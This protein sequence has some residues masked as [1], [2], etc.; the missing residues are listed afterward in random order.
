MKD[1][2][3]N[4]HGLSEYAPPGLCPLLYHS[5]LPYIIT[6]S[7]GGWF[8][9]VKK[10]KDLDFR[11]DINAD[12]FGR[13]NADCLYP[14]EVLV[15]CP[16]IHASVIAGLGPYSG[17]GGQP[18]LLLRILSENGGC[19][20]NYAA[21]EKII[22]SKDD[23]KIPPAEYN[24]LFPAL[25]SSLTGGGNQAFH[26]PDGLNALTLS[27]A[28]I[29]TRCRYHKKKTGYKHPFL[30]GDYCPDMFHFIY[31]G[32]L[33]LLY[34]QDKP[35]SRTQIFHYSCPAGQG[36]MVITAEK[37]SRLS[38][39]PAALKKI[40]EKIF[41]AVFFPYDF[42]DD[43]IVFTVEKETETAAC[44]M[45]KGKKYYLNMSDPRYPCPASLHALYPYMLLKARLAR[46]P[47]PD[48]E[49]FHCPGCK[50]IIYRCEIRREA[51]H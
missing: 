22:L 51:G 44:P 8:G 19:A 36:K 14:N 31:P 12:D 29:E 26:C 24:A 7:E 45:A 46:M 39:R 42:I 1:Y 33:A 25:L 30:P 21:G 13:A 6:I 4:L 23:F 35:A 18:G 11:K 10:T 43:D 3:V 34:A 49:Y 40:L 32:L 17:A 50:G 15:R 20:A 5:L 27:A 16:N 37:V 38:P 48:D 28:N 41:N 2:L 9:W 47:W